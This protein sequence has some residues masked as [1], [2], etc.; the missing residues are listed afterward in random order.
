MKSSKL[1]FS[2]IKLCFENPE[3]WA[4]KFRPSDPLAQWVLDIVADYK[5]E[6]HRY[7]NLATF[8][9]Y[10]QDCCQEQQL[11]ILEL[12]LDIELDNDFVIKRIL[13]FVK[14]QNLIQAIKEA[15][16]LLAQNKIQDAE[17]TLL[18]GAELVYSRTIDYFK[19]NSEEE[20]YDFVPTGYECLDIPL[21]GGVH[22]GNL[23]LII[24]SK[25]AGKSTVLLNFGGNNVE[26]GGTT[27]HISYEDSEAQIR[28]RYNKKFS[29]KKKRPKGNLFIHVFPSGSS[30][31]ADCE[32]LVSAYKPNLVLVDYLS[33]MGWENTKQ[34]KSTDFGDRARGLKAI[35][36]RH[37]CGVWT[38]QQAGKDF[39][40]GD[41]DI[42]AESG[43][44]SYE[45][46]QV[47]DAT[48][49]LN[50]TSEERKNKKIRI[51]VD[52]NRNGPD[53]MKDLFNIDYNE[54]LLTEV[55]SMF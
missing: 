46:A 52:R 24:G 4:V 18:K 27:L 8:L 36:Q 50:Q 29:H 39:K 1:E 47:A 48:V 17:K 16:V 37:M 33:E 6:F 10:S 35:S 2:F 30:T 12:A 19:D 49:C 15:D 14:K 13:D 9:E 20:D 32:A 22:L 31:C 11:K 3:F 21:G 54:M 25:S 23:G 40:Y 53:G 34:D 38:A 26:A 7:P 43:F 51:G 28:T 42:T 44:W 55:K 45:P 5:D 41:E